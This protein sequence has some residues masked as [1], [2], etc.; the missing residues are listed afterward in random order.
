MGHSR[1][2]LG[3]FGPFGVIFGPLWA[4]LGHFWTFL[5]HFVAFLNKFSEISFFCGIVGVKI[6][7]FRMYARLLNEVAAAVFCETG[8]E[9]SQFLFL[10]IFTM[11]RLGP[12]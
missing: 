2:I 3:H 10:R 1:A 8:E 6:L 7:A 12:T 9:G 11:R 4:I 5:G